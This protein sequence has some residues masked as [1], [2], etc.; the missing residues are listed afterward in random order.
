M[1]WED[2]YKAI[3]EAYHTFTQKYA[4]P[5]IERRCMDV[6]YSGEIESCP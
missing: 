6:L 4:I 3:Q 2:F 5:T 1:N